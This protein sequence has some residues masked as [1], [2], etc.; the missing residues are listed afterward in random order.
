[1]SY[2]KLGGNE[3]SIK[4]WVKVFERDDKMDLIHL[5][6]SYNSFTLKESMTLAE[7]LANNHTIYGFHFKGNI[8]SVDCK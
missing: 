3:N 8:G 2:N 6:L 7:G 1:M 4:E 5:D